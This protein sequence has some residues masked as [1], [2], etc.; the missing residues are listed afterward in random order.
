MNRLDLYER[1]EMLEKQLLSLQNE[2]RQCLDHPKTELLPSL[3]M[4][5]TGTNRLSLSLSG[6]TLTVKQKNKVIG[7]IELREG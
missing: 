6:S 4:V 1:V 3:P 7:K 5:V 2:L